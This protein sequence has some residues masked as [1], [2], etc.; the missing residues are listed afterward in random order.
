MLQILAVDIYLSK[1]LEF[2]KLLRQNIYFRTYNRCST[3]ELQ[4]FSCHLHPSL[5]LRILQP[6]LYLRRIVM[7]QTGKQQ[8]TEKG[9]LFG[10][11]LTSTQK[12]F[13][14][15]ISLWLLLRG[16]HAFLVRSPRGFVLWQ[17]RYLRHLLKAFT[18]LVVFLFLACIEEIS[19]P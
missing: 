2:L 8:T 14:R 12:P 16:C 18:E 3:C 11:L 4:S 6:Y 17:R 1:V 9:I 5:L 10:N 7:W 15:H 13:Q 19:S